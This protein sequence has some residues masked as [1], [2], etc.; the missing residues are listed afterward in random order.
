VV[1][2]LRELPGSGDSIPKGSGADNTWYIAQR[3]C[4]IVLPVVDTGLMNS[5][6]LSSFPLEEL[7]V[8]PPLPQMMPKAVSRLSE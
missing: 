1:N 2:L 7:E 8:Q 3:R 4:P 6:L 5:K